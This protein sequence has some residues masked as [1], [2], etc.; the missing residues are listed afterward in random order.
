MIPSGMSNKGKPTGKKITPNAEAVSSV[1][2]REILIVQYLIPETRDKKP[3][4]AHNILL[5]KG[6]CVSC[7]VVVSYVQTLKFCVHL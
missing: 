7:G 1:S 5:P 6:G 2:S 3:S 4:C